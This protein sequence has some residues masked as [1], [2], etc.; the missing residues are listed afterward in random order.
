MP[1]QVNKQ[2]ARMHYM[3]YRMQGCPICCKIYQREQHRQK[4]ATPQA[5]H[6]LAMAANVIFLAKT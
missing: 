6:A 1:D 3:L 5:L 2:D 4:G